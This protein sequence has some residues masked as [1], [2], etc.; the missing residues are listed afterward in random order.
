VKNAEYRFKDKSAFIDEFATVLKDSGRSPQYIQDRGGPVV[1]T[2]YGWLMGKTCRPQLDTMRRALRPLGKD[3]TITDSVRNIKDLTKA[4]S[5]AM[6]A[7]WRERLKIRRRKPSKK[8]G[9]KMA[10]KRK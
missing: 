10:K 6:A 9:R 3:L 4:D 8:T 1:A 2:L 5:R 7:E